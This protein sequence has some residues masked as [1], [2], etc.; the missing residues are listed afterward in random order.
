M[1]LAERP[2]PAWF[3]DAGLGIFVHWT[4]ASV[5]AYAPVGP[6]P[7]EL[8]ATSGW[9]KAM[10]ESPYVEWYQNS[11]AIAGSPVYRHH[12]RTYGKL[13]YD[14]FVERFLPPRLRGRALARADRGVQA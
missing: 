13:P 8:A 12:R 9:E 4:A 11:L 5:P 6:S 3:R 7:F 10:A 14:A 1:T 2:L